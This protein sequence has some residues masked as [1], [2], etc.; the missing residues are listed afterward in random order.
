MLTE[1]HDTAVVHPGAE[2]GENVSIGP[3][4]VIGEHVKIG[5]NCR[6]GSHVLIDGYTT[7]GVNNRVFHGASIGTEPQDLKYDGSVSHVEIGDD[8]VFREFVTVNSATEENGK[9][10]IGSRNLL[11]AYVH[12]AH[13]CIIG[14]NVILANSVNLG[15][16]VTIHDYAIVGG[17][18]PV[19]QFVSIGAH[20]F[21]GGGSRIAKDIPPY[22]KVAGNP[23]R[24]GGL[25]SIGLKRR[26]FTIE[27]RML[28]KKAF[29]V[30]YRSDLNVTQ[31]LEKI[32]QE[33]PRT[34]ETGI[35]ADFIR[36]SKRGITK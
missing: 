28:I 31:A 11:M 19:H 7:M 2:I 13:N 8:N 1:V 18:V 33:L 21:I 34:P 17:I 24:I 5:D 35:I 20:S 10:I 12:I 30:I 23:P 25:N 22:V 15:G 9:T 27:Q 32:E 16:H 26:G 36:N 4:A 6:L 14:N 29:C 3:Y